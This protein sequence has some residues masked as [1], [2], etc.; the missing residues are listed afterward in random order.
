MPAVYGWPNQSKLNNSAAAELN[1]TAADC[2]P[3]KYALI[4]RGGNNKLLK[5]AEIGNYAV[6]EFIS[7]R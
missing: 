3:M 2:E 5:C 7:A 4:V 1:S 6:V